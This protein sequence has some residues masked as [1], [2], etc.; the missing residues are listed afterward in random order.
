MVVGDKSKA[1]LSRVLPQKLALTFNGVGKDVP[2]FGDACA[3]ADLILTSGVEFDSVS[4]P[5]FSSMHYYHLSFIFYF[6]LNLPLVPALVPSIVFQ[7]CPREAPIESPLGPRP[8]WGSGSQAPRIFLLEG[9]L[10]P[11]PFRDSRG[12][13]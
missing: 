11:R 3:I 8:V 12:G 10:L 5:S 9:I 1:Q 13:V 7:T 4:S 6:V 2:T